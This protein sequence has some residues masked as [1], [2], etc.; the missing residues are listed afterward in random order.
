[1]YIQILLY[2]YIYYIY[3][4]YIIIWYISGKW[5]AFDLEDLD[6]NCWSLPEIPN[7]WPWQIVLFLFL[8]GR[9]T[10]RNPKITW[11]IL[12]VHIYIYIW[13][14]FITT[15]LFS[16]TGILVRIRGVIPN[17]PQQFRLV[18]YYNLYPDKYIYICVVIVDGPRVDLRP[19]HRDENCS[20]FHV[21][22]WSLDWLET[23]QGNPMKSLGKPWF[24]TLV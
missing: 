8:G 22:D 20:L 24:D 16:L 23:L 19:S 14:N 12:Y 17:W 10:R 3:I 18:N 15:S 2:Y 11:L 6:S 9:R 4:N 21:L 13:V 5:R 7:L 1:M